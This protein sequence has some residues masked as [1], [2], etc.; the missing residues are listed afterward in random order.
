MRMVEAECAS[1]T[2]FETLSVVSLRHWPPFAMACSHAGLP[3]P[4]DLWLNL[5]R[6]ARSA[7]AADGEG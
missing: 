7:E 3:L 6:E 1:P 5:L 4:P 2:G